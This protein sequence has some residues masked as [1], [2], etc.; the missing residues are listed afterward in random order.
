MGAD[1]M[2]W[3]YCSQPPSQNIRFGYGPAEEVKRK[4]LT[5]WNSAAF[6]IQ[7][8]EI[9]EFAPCTYDD[10]AAGP[11]MRTRFD[12]PR[13]LAC[14]AHA[15]A[16]GRVR[17]LVRGLPD[18]GRDGGA[19]ALHRRS[20]ELVHPPEPATLLGGDR[21]WRRSA[22]SGSGLSR[23]SGSSD[24]SCRSWPSI[25]GNTWWRVVAKDAPKSVFLAGWPAPEATRS[26][27][28]ASCDHGCDSASRR[29]R[30][31]RALERR[32]QA[33]PAA[34]RGNSSS[35]GAKS[36]RASR[37]ADRGG[38]ARCVTS[39][40]RRDRRLERAREARSTVAGT[41]ARQ[42]A[43]DSCGKRSPMETSIC[44]P[45][46]GVYLCSATSSPPKRSTSSALLPTGSRSPRRP[47]LVVALDTR[48]DDEL[49][50]EGR[51]LDVIHEL[52]RMR[53]RRRAR[54]DRPNR[55]SLRAEEDSLAEVF[56]VHGDRIAGET[57][58]VKVE[59]A[60]GDGLEI[61]KGLRPLTRTHGS[62]CRRRAY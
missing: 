43:S 44:S 60:A 6:F 7:Y 19:R 3:M 55:D 27:G 61:A 40:F 37:R 59:A 30:P 41:E 10:L 11:P 31:G 51:A 4:L 25:S 42:G 13:P 47:G 53:R 1:V 33:A 49:A 26:I 45:S 22:R 39:S 56:E 29:A 15:R 32:R 36:R 14:L 48:I 9:A 5:L 24:R 12:R 38:A 17:R 21:R 46:G 50:L 58:A 62:P 2:R 57:L 20:L 28:R 52:Q 54:A 8:A 35:R 16:R 34:S 18:R 23:R